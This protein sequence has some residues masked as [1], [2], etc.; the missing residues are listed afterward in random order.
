MLARVTWF[1]KTIGVPYVPVTPTFP[2]LGPA[3]LLPIPSKWTLCFGPLIDLSERYGPDAAEDRILVNRLAEEV[4][5]Q[6]QEMIDDA[7]T[8]RRSILFG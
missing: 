1:A 7:L 4:R 6:I 2:L 3:G 5:S 8:R